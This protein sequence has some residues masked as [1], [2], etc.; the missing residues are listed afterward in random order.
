VELKKQKTTCDI[1]VYHQSGY[2]VSVS[3]L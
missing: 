3:L 2:I 1:D